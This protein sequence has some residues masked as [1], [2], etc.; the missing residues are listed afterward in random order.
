[1]AP[2]I[3]LDSLPVTA[4]DRVSLAAGLTKKT[5]RSLFAVLGPKMLERI[6]P[7]VFQTV[8]M[9]EANVEQ[10]ASFFSAK[11]SPATGHASDEAK[12]HRLDRP[13]NGYL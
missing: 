8:E 1:M 13:C 3:G 6:A 9:S 4:L 10:I 2:S 7:K 11:V 5:G 12:G